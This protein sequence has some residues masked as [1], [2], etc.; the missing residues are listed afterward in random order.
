MR[1]IGHD[2]LHI[3]GEN[4]S[5]TPASAM[6]AAPTGAFSLVSAY[7]AQLGESPVWCPD[8]QSLWWVDCASKALINTRLDGTEAVWPAPETIGFVVL[9]FGKILAGLET[10]L[11]AFDPITGRFEQ[12]MALDA[13]ALRFHD[14]P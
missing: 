9:A 8:T 14:K 4:M 3:R 6:K 1:A 13:P 7:R 5:G 11:F 2:R 10:G 12:V